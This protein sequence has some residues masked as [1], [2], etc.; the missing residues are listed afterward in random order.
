MKRLHEHIRA[1]IEK[2]NE[3]N[4]NLTNKHKKDRQFSLG[5]LVWVHLQKE[6]FPARRKSK[7]MPCIDGSFKILERIGNNDHKLELLT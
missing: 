7:L 1:Q 4:K 2:K 3:V 6:R 5:D